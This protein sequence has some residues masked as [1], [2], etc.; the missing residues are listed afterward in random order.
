MIRGIDV[1]KIKAHTFGAFGLG[2]PMSC[3]N[4]VEIIGLEIPIARFIP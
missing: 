1:V 4:R 3:G 2:R